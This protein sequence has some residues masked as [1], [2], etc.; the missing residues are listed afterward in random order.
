MNLKSGQMNSMNC[1]RQS[2]GNG[3]NKGIGRRQVEQRVKE[4]SSGGH[5]GEGMLGHTRE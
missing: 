3:T 4:E 2:L 5:A 1:D